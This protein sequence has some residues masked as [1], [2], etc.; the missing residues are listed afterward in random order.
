MASAFLQN[1]LTCTHNHFHNF[2][3]QLHRRGPSGGQE[4]FGSNEQGLR[5][6]GWREKEDGAG[7]GV[8]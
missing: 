1:S 8:G 7:E 5:N 6:E 4:L 2:S 3:S